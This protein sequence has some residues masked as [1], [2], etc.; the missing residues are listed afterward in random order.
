MSSELFVY[1]FYMYLILTTTQHN[2]IIAI[3]QM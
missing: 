1:L 3:L 2:S